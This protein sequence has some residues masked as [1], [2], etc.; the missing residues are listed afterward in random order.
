MPIKHLYNVIQYSTPIQGCTRVAENIIS[1]CVLSTIDVLRLKLVPR[2]SIAPRLR[3]KFVTITLKR[4]QSENTA[5]LI[6]CK[7]FERSSRVFAFLRNH[8]TESRGAE[9]K[10]L[11]D[12]DALT[13][14]QIVATLV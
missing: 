13:K 2:L 8:T 11:T 6:S 9:S 5:T 1:V 14:S 4:L 12:Q 3:L 7:F 10:H